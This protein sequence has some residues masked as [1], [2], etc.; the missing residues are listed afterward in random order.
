MQLLGR[1]GGRA[2][3]LPLLR[4]AYDGAA[5]LQAALGQRSLSDGLSA[6]ILDTLRAEIA[7]SMAAAGQPEAIPALAAYAA[8]DDAGKVIAWRGFIELINAAS[9]GLAADLQ[10]AAGL[11]WPED[12]G[13]GAFAVMTPEIRQDALA[14]LLLLEI[15]TGTGMDEFPRRIALL[16]QVNMPEERL[17]DLSFAAFGAQVNNAAFGQAAAFLP[18]IEAD[19]RTLR[20]PYAQNERNVLFSAGILALHTEAGELRAITHFARLRDDLLKH[21]PPGELFWPALRG[22]LVALNRVKRGD[23]AEALLLEFAASVPNMPDDLL[24]R[25]PAGA[26]VMQTPAP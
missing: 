15:A 10:A 7:I 8:V 5:A 6:S 19:L 1:N 26:A 4:L 14:A 11:D 2:E 13:G 16:G 24:A 21:G 23:E 20:Q 22:E 3:I 9:H 18:L 17:R 12:L 25:L